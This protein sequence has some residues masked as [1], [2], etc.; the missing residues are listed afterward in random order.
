LTTRDPNSTR[1]SGV[2]SGTEKEEEARADDGAAT[3][4]QDEAR[5]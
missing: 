4:K 5:S 2:G 3:E 1:T